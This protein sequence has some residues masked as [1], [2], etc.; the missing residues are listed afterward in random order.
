MTTTLTKFY[1]VK[2]TKE[3]V[4]LTV[5]IGDSQMGITAVSLD[6]AQLVPGHLGTLTLDLGAGPEIKG[7]TLVCT[8]TV[9]DVSAETNHT[10]VTYALQGGIE[11]YSHLL[12]ETVPVNGGKM[13]YTASFWFFS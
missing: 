6:G 9:S 12:E 10:S 3:K 11:P 4:I 5:T 13:S 2:K 8:T 7:K 1:P